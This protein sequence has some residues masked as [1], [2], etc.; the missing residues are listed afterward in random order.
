[1]REM[2]FLH[3]DGRAARPPQTRRRR[4]AEA[5]GRLAE[6]VVADC[7]Q[8]RGYN[9]LARRLRTGAGEIDLIVADAQTLLFIE[10]KARK[11]MNEAAYAVQPR[12]QRQLLLA[13]EAAI[14]MN[15]TWRRPETRFDVAL[16]CG[17]TVDYIEDAIR[18]N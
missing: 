18:H 11:T 3:Q 4:A 5:C 8:A 16:V 10:V 6:N 12:Q 1:M 13:A 9:V 15:E 17:G 7:W 14:A 2:P